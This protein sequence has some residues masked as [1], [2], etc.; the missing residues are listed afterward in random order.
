[1][2]LTIFIKFSSKQLWK[3]NNILKLHLVIQIIK[4]HIESTQFCIHAK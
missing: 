4:Q 1:M 3:L 2:N